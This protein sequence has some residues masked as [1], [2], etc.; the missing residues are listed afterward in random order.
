MLSSASANKE[1]PGHP[2]STCLL[3]S[4]YLLLQ[5]FPLLMCREQ[6]CFSQSARAQYNS[7]ILLPLVYKNLLP[8]TALQSS[9]L[10][11]RLEAT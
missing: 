6:P 1:G 2:G 5:A 4:G 11:A 10:S 3:S 9:F 7:L 8:C